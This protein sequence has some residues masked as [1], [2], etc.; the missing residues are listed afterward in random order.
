MFVLR[1]LILKW[2]VTRA[3]SVDCWVL[4]VI[5]RGTELCLVGLGVRTGREEFMFSLPFLRTHETDQS[6]NFELLVF[7]QG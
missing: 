6:Q 2:P 4:V 3:S 5:V 7:L 1:P